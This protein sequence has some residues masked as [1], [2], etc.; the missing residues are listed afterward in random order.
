MPVQHNFESSEFDEAVA[1]AGRRA[2]DA[3]LAAGLPVFYLDR[4]GLN[5][6]QQPDGRKFEI[7]WIPGAP[8]GSN[9]EVIRELTPPAT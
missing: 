2:F 5:L 3:T 8:S 9:Y 4:D 6:M 1:A 7:R